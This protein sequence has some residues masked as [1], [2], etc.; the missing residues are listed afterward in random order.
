[1]DEDQ[2]INQYLV[3]LKKVNDIIER[4][5]ATGDY[6]NQ[7]LID[8]SIILSDELPKL[9]FNEEQLDVLRNSIKLK[10]MSL[11]AMMNNDKRARN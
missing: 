4:M 2:L 8:A 3:T 7:Q 9:M 5:K 10:C 1:M 6:D 11:E